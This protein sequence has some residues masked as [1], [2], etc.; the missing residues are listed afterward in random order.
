[1]CCMLGFSVCWDTVWLCSP[2]PHASL[3]GTCIHMEAAREQAMVHS[4]FVDQVLL[5]VVLAAMGSYLRTSSRGSV[6]L[7]NSVT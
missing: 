2:L 5:V 4:D 3:L 7:W 1:M 6:A